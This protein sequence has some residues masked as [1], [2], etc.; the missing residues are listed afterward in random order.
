MLLVQFI[1]EEELNK[2]IPVKNEEAPSVEEKKEKTLD[3]LV[4]E[5]L[6]GNGFQEKKPEARNANILVRNFDL[7][8]YKIN[9]E[10]KVVEVHY[11]SPIIRLPNVHKNAKKLSLDLEI[12]LAPLQSLQVC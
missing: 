10:D 8:I 6:E 9:E 4:K 2:A 3:E 11:N 12:M 1:A 7:E 5:Y